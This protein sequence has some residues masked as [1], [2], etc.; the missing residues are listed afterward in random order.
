LKNILLNQFHWNYWVNFTFGYRPDLDEVEDILYNLHYKLDRRL[1]KHVPQ[2]N[3]L[4]VEE[5]IEW[6]LFPE[7]KGRGLHYHCFFKFNVKPTVTSYKD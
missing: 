3:T 6:F 2:K 4:S 5:R 7:L 1:I